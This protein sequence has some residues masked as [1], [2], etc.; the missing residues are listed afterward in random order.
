[1]TSPW[2][3]VNVGP[4]SVMFVDA[5]PQPCGA[6]KLPYNVMLTALAGLF[7]TAV[8]ASATGAKA[9]KPEIDS[10]SATSN[11]VFVSRVI[12]SS[13]LSRGEPVPPNK[14]FPKRHLRLCDRCGGW[15]FPP[16]AEREAFE[17]TDSCETGSYARRRCPGSATPASRPPRR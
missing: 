14:A 8:V 11:K 2:W 4:G 16:C 7:E 3:T 13:P 5:H 6:V 17:P 15:D 10:P 1:M 12:D 9:A